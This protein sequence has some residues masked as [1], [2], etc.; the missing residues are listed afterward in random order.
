[1]L[2]DGLKTQQSSGQHSHIKTP[3]FVTD[4]E[5]GGKFWHKTG[6]C[7]LSSSP[8]GDTWHVLS[9]NWANDQ[10]GGEGNWAGTWAGEEDYSPGHSRSAWVPSWVLKDASAPGLEGTQPTPHLQQKGIGG[11]AL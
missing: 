5:A 11:G 3:L 10:V 6:S 8:Q 7:T 9:V 2:A 1:M 4:R